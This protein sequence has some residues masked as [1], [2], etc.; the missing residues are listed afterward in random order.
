MKLRKIGYIDLL[1]SRYTAK[2]PQNDVE[3][4]TPLGSKALMMVFA[5]LPISMVSSALIFI[6]ETIQVGIKNRL[7]KN[8]QKV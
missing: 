1:M 8:E 2:I 6:S 4:W 5:L 3:E 7:K